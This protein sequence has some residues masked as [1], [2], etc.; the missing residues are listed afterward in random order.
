VGWYHDK[1]NDYPSW[2]ADRAYF[3]MEVYKAGVEKALSAKGGSWPSTKEIAQAM[4]GIEVESLGGKGS[5]RA[6]HIAEQVFHQ[7]LSTTDITTIYS[8]E[9]Q[10][11]KADDDFWKWLEAKEWNI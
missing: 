9:L 11:P 4:S 1:F 8:D 5:M 2:E 3:S 10:K 6:D 7:G